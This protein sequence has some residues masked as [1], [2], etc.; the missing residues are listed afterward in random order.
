MKKTLI[1][2]SLLVLLCLQ[3]FAATD[4]NREKFINE[5]HSQGFEVFYLVEDKWDNDFGLIYTK[6]DVLSKG[7][8]SKNKY[9][10]KLCYFKDPIDGEYGMQ[11]LPMVLESGETV[12]VQFSSGRY[13]NTPRL[14]YGGVESY[15]K[16]IEAQN[17]VASS[18]T[19]FDG[20]DV[21]I[22]DVKTYSF[23]EK[24]F[25]SDGNTIWKSSYEF[26][27]K[28]VDQTP[29][30]DDSQR[31]EF[32]SSALDSGIS[33]LYDDFDE[34]TQMIV[35]ATD[36]CELYAYVTKNGTIKNPSML[37]TYTGSS[38][39]FI[40]SIRMKSD[41]LEYSASQSSY[42][43]V[44][45]SGNVYEAVTL[46]VEPGNS[47]FTF[48]KGASEKGQLKIRMSGSSG[49]VD[50]PFNSNEIKR[51][52]AFLNVIEILKKH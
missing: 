29:F 11:F 14:I 49:S 16:L 12:Y 44:M 33:I 3:V 40:S 45:S 24:W 41:D 1:F 22:V 9:T 39:K 23:G 21:S 17:L 37:L 26:L 6:P 48:L 5:A 30:E 43:S 8:L 35:S 25:L 46:F 4:D 13:G 27:K 32:I 20:Y 15:D 28:L 42:R 7:Y 50:L 38:W 52:N 10:G 34:E 18:F 51:I 31:K 19:L 36:D 47:L 2:I